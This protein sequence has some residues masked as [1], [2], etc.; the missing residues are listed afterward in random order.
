MTSFSNHHD[1]A[2]LI[3]VGST[4]QPEFISVFR[5]CRANVAQIAVRRSPQEL[6]Q[7]PAGFVKRIIFART[8]RRPLPSSLQTEILG[9]YAD[10][11][12]LTLSSLLCDGESRTGEPWLGM[13]NIRFSR[14]QEIVPAWLEPCG[15]RPKRSQSVGSVLVICDRYEMA[16]PYLDWSASHGH[17]A[18]WS[19]TLNNAAARNVTNVIWDDSIASPLSAEGW[20]SR[21]GI[22]EALQI[23]HMWLTTQPYAAQIDAAIAGGV[24]Q[25]FTK[26]VALQV[27]LNRLH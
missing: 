14:W 21:L 25:V 22:A 1:P 20:R 4:S 26:P 18:L 8:D 7:R 12:C 24:S 23:H 2:T 15:N 9:R 6:I 16:E 3:W 11:E 19:R 5:Y 27:L 17:T 10:S 13:R